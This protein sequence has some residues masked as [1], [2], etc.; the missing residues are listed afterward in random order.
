MTSNFEEFKLESGS[1]S[2]WD[3]QNAVASTA[4]CLFISTYPSLSLLHF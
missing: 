2:A 4:V 3:Q 1:N